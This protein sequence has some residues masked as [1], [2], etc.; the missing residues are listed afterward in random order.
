MKP[1]CESYSTR[2]S[3]GQVEL[4][5]ATPS[6]RGDK[7][8]AAATRSAPG[9]SLASP[10]VRAFWDDTVAWLAVTVAALH[11]S[12]P[13]DAPAD[14]EDPAPLPPLQVGDAWGWG[15]WAV[16]RCTSCC[17]QLTHCAPD[18]LFVSCSFVLLLHSTR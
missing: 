16:G 15:A 5:P 7:G 8:K 6:L 13:T 12:A 18:F 9:P 4:E 3:L 1:R 17:R 10:A 11:D 14:G 2:H